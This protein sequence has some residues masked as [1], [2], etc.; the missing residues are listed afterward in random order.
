MITNYKQFKLMLTENTENTNNFENLP[1]DIQEQIKEYGNYAKDLEFSKEDTK[2]LITDVFVDPANTPDNLSIHFINMYMGY[3][4]DYI[5]SIPD[6]E[7]PTGPIFSDELTNT[8]DLPFECVMYVENND[9]IENLINLL[10]SKIK[11]NNFK[12]IYENNIFY[13]NN[14]E[15][16]NENNKKIVLNLLKENGAKNISNE[17]KWKRKIK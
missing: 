7:F 11:I 15:L 4:V 13:I 2:K 3:I 14:L 8:N 5:D 12:T 1:L 10:N 9:K 16:L 6:S 17:L